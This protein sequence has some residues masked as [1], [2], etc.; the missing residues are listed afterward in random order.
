[1]LARDLRLLSLLLRD[2]RNGVR[3]ALSS[4]GF[5]P[6]C[7]LAF[8]ERHSLLKFLYRFLEE[9][10]LLSGCPPDFVRDLQHHHDIRVKIGEQRIGEMFSLRPRFRRAGIDVIFLKGPFLA[11]RY[12]GEMHR[13]W[14]WD[15][16]LLVR[17]KNDVIR[18]E[19]L[20]REAGY[21]RRS[22]L[23]LSHGATMHFTH[24]LEFEKDDTVLDLHWSL[25]SHFSF[26]LDY[27]RLWETSES[28]SM[29][30]EEFRVLS[31]EY[32]LVLIILAI[33]ND[34]QRGRL[35]VK[36]LVDLYMI[37]RRAGEMI[38]WKRF[39]RRRNREG[40][41]HISL[42]AMDLAL[43]LLNGW[44]QFPHLDNTMEQYGV[45]PR[46]SR[47]SLYLRLFEAPGRV[48]RNKLWAFN[49]YRGGPIPAF[50]WWALSLPVKIAVHR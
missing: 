4:G 49:L 22:I 12:Y 14:F 8:L 37:F 11:R 6:Q 10:D 47:R 48:V 7:F 1:M 5:Q 40:L 2:D 31:R 34:V 36:S 18:S 24:N 32:V 45:I 17:G 43:T 25:G 9:T 41:L 50:F 28:M 13:R 3:H 44:G 20:L 27:G 35:R 16:D 29:A 26:C 30:G 33:L 46:R 23:F 21:V 19:T 15:I 38:Y 42:F 39:F